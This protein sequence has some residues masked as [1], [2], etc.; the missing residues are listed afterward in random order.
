MWPL[1]L[2]GAAFGGI[3]FAV[4]RPVPTAPTEPPGQRGFMVTWDNTGTDH[5]YPSLAAVAIEARRLDDGGVVT[6]VSGSL[7]GHIDG[8]GHLT[9]G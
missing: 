6:R 5:W 8:G 3:I 1:L 2:L 4:T 7:V 9:K